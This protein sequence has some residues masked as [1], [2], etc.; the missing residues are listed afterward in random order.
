MQLKKETLSEQIYHILRDDILHQN[1][2]GGERLTLKVLQNRFGVS[3]TPIREALTRLAQD[4][5]VVYYSNIGIEV[6]QLNRHDLEELYQFMGD[7]DALAIDY[8]SG[9]SQ[10]EKLL[11][12]LQENQAQA[13]RAREEHRLEDWM[14]AS[15]RFHLIFYDYCRNSRLADSAQKLRSQLSIFSSQ[16]ELLSENQEL[17]Q[18]EHE[19]IYHLYIEEKISDACCKMKEHLIHSL[20]FALRGLEEL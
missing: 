2:K 15:D 1:I 18:K 19:E 14:L 12:E 13:Q 20:E 7:L 9:S 3:S 16:Y 4:N 6:I 8:A 11:Q 17:I 10:Q 5:L